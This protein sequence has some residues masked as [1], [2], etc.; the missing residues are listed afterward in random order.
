[1]NNIKC[2]A[3]CRHLVQTPKNNRYGDVENFCI[4]T[5][6][7]CIAIYKDRE[8]IGMYVPGGKKLECRYER[9]NN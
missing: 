9:K 4:A 3:T 5:G 1:M 8:K 6:Y 7:Y 2:C